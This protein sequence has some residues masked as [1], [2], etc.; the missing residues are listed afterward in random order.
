MFAFVF[1]GMHKFVVLFLFFGVLFMPMRSFSQHVDGD[2]TK[3]YKNKLIPV[4]AIFYSPE[5][6]LGF[7]AIGVFLFKS[8]KDWH[9]RTSNFDFAAVHTSRNQ[10]II[11]P[12]YTIFTKGE[13]FYIRGTWIYA[14]KAA[15]TWFPLGNDNVKDDG[16]EVNFNNFRFNNKILRRVLP[17]LYLGIQQQ[18]SYVY[19]LDYNTTQIKQN[20]NYS[21][22]LRAILLDD[23]NYVKHNQTVSGLGLSTLYD[24]RDNILNPF[25]GF[26]ADVGFTRF[27]PLLGSDYKFTN[28]YIDLRTYRHFEYKPDK[29][30]F[31][32][33]TLAI[34]VIFNFNT[35]KDEAI[36]TVSVP[37]NGKTKKTYI[38]ENRQYRPPINQLA[39]LGGAAVLRGFYRGRFKD[40]DA[41]V[42]QSEYRQRVYKRWGMTIFGGVGEV[43]SQLSDIDFKGLNYSYG[44]GI[45]YMIRK[46]E[47]L[48]LRLDLGFGNRDSKGIYG[49]I[50]E[51][52]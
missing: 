16:L 22:S 41:L 50:S 19:G 47:R 18:F 1:S 36:S 32:S 21:P 8:G 42:L 12:T 28:F 11:E 14:V 46:N 35:A 7:G 37:A 39:S 29:T 13:K 5:T 31:S 52:F 15:E 6:K 40:I 26:F 24:T 4:P 43:A 34:N 10:T 51:A 48:N 25:R 3:P 23:L 44:A 38:I 9:T 20:T 27:T 30:W 33:G 2:T 49:G 17:H 45:R